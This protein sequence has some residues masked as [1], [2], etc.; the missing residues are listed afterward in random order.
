MT[1]KS[2]RPQLIKQYKQDLS[3]V[4]EKV[5]INRSQEK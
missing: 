1:E 2:L 5:M 4:F 3:V